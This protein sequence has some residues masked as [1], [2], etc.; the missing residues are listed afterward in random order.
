MLAL[1]CNGYGKVRRRLPDLLVGIEGK[2]IH[3][4]GVDVH[5]F[6]AEGSQVSRRGDGRH[7]KVEW[8]DGQI[9]VDVQFA[10]N[11]AGIGPRKR[12]FLYER[13]GRT[14]ESLEV[15][16]CAMAIAGLIEQ[17]AQSSSCRR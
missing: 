3:Q 16:H 15:P 10:T 14:V 1:K 2:L 5:A 7:I 9:I 13:F 6:V 8:F 17:P 11:D 12:N 4:A